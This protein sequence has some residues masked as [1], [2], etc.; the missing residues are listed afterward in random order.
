MPTLVP[1]HSIRSSPESGTYKTETG[2]A[3]WFQVDDTA[4]PN[5]TA[6]NPAGPDTAYQVG[7][8]S[9]VRV[10]TDGGNTWSSMSHGLAGPF[11]W[12]FTVDRTGTRL[13][14]GTGYGVYVWEDPDAVSVD[15]DPGPWARIGFRSIH[16]S[17]ITSGTAIFRFVLDSPGQVAFAVH[18]A[19]G[20]M[21]SSKSPLPYRAGPAEIRWAARASRDGRPLTPGV[22]VVLM[23]LDGLPAGTRKLVLIE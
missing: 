17:P 6:I 18:D 16:P 13:L 4:Y 19:A 1:A 15:D 11:V 7:W 9:G 23:T 5:A 8:F 3:V 10:S 21:V 20:R 12:S 2:G 14:A 22:Y